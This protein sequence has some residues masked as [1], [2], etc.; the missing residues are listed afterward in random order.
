[1]KYKYIK[2]D[3]PKPKA[4]EVL[5]IYNKIVVIPTKD[6]L[7]PLNF[8][9]KHL[10]YNALEDKVYQYLCSIDIDSEIA[11]L[12]S[13]LH[14][15]ISEFCAWYFSGEGGYGWFRGIDNF[16][17]L[18][19]DIHTWLSYYLTDYLDETIGYNIYKHIKEQNYNELIKRFINFIIERYPEMIGYALYNENEDNPNLI[20]CKRIEI[21]E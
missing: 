11:N 1:M 7:P 2:Y 13:K 14:F 18:K 15:Q 20:I 8:R 19:V 6:I 3:G 4:W 16:H 9:E 10:I 12:R 21:K 5:D 17:D